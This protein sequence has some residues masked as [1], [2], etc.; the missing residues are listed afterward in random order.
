MSFVDMLAIFTCITEYDE[1]V[2]WNTIF[3][4]EFQKFV[5]ENITKS[6]VENH[7]LYKALLKHNAT[8]S[9][10]VIKQLA[11]TCAAK[12][13]HGNLKLAALLKE[14]RVVGGKV[15]VLEGKVVGL[16]DEVAGITRVLNTMQ[17]EKNDGQILT[18]SRNKQGAPGAGGSLSP[19]IS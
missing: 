18:S 19:G 10:D 9:T 6:F 13:I 14:V 5:T 11:G 7:D 2:D 15:A 12:F 1:Y 16:I 4:V 17:K 3:R 8:Q